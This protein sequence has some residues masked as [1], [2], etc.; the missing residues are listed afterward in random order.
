MTP[1]ILAYLASFFGVYCIIICSCSILC[2]VSVLTLFMF[3][4]TLIITTLIAIIA[5]VS[6]EYISTKI[7]KKQNNDVIE[8]ISDE[9]N[10]M[11]SN[12]PS[13]DTKYIMAFFV[14]H[15]VIFYSLFDVSIKC[16]ILYSMLMYLCSYVF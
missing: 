3:I 9:N 4:P 13:S 14:L 10:N 12:I 15:C 1:E 16:I 2:D 5:Y 6:Y 7:T 8:L 11:A